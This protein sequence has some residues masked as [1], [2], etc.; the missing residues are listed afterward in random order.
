MKKVL[1]CVGLVV[2]FASSTWA[3]PVGPGGRIYFTKYTSTSNNPDNQLYLLRIDVDTSWAMTAESVTAGVNNVMC[4]VTDVNGG[5]Y[6]Y[7]THVS[8]QSPEVLYPRANP[9]GTATG[10]LG[11]VWLDHCPDTDNYWQYSLVTPTGISSATTG[12]LH[13]ALYET[14]SD[15]HTGSS[16][17]VG[18]VADPKGD[19][20]GGPHGVSVWGGNGYP[21]VWN[22]VNQNKDLTDDCDT[23]DY[24]GWGR[25]HSGDPEIGGAPNDA[26][27]EDTIWT[28][29]AYG[30][31]FNFSRYTGNYT[32]TGHSW[33][34]PTSFYDPKVPGS[35]SAYTPSGGHAVGDTDGDGNTDLYFI[36]TSQTSSPSIIRLAS[37]GGTE[38]IDNSDDICK[39]IY[40][41]D[42]LAGSENDIGSGD[43]ELVKDPTTG[44]WTLLILDGGSSW[45][46]TDARILAIELG[47]NGDFSGASDG[48]VVVA[49]GIETGGPTGGNFSCQYPGMEFDADP[50]GGVIPEPGTLLLIGTGVL[51]LVGYIRRRRMS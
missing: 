29:S 47:S 40:D 4:Q 14:S 32:T 51:G 38:H 27:D 34:G 11:E 17:T 19:A 28:Y 6:D 22:D 41:D 2:L 12:V 44:K 39:V 23:F 35:V 45:S 7:R 8:S 50:A 37:L 9:D 42:T 43:V 20:L 26:T 1:L 36:C 13:P 33:T 25:A 3:A 49:T 24:P 46:A 21:A 5:G 30:Q 16:G 31:G 15:P 18:N 10:E 48:V